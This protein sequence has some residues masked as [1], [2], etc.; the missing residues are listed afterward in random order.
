MRNWYRPHKCK[1]WWGLIILTCAYQGVRNVSFSENFDYALPELSHAFCFCI[2]PTSLQ[3]LLWRKFAQSE[4]R[5][6][7][8]TA[9]TSKR[10][11]FVIIV[12]GFQ[13][14]TIITKHSVLDVVA[15]LDPPL[16]SYGVIR[17]T[18]HKTIPWK[19]I[20]ETC[21]RLGYSI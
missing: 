14:F 21:I 9:A 18:W 17:I 19:L 20:S 16:W 11:R 8:R 5:G 1:N 13:P 12:N 10:E 2:F 7:S 4:A 15:A 3:Y 6:G